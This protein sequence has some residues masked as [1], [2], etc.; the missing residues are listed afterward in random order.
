MV[1]NNNEVIS[2]V[3]IIVSGVETMYKTFKISESMTLLSRALTM[4]KKKVGEL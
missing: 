2:G 4:R 3:R 1:F